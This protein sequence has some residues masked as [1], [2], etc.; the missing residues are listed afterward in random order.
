MASCEMCERGLA[1]TDIVMATRRKYVHEYTRTS[2][3]LDQMSEQQGGS[4]SSFGET[5]LDASEMPVN[6]LK[7]KDGDED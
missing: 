4:A 3:T 5:G 2:L 1:E 6:S 7:R